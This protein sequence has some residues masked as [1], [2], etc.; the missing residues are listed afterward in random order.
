MKNTNTKTCEIEN[1]DNKILARTWC[2]KHYVRWYTKGDP[3]AKSQVAK[4]DSPEHSFLSRIKQDGECLI[5]LGPKNPQGYGSITL[6]GKTQP[7]YRYAYEREHGPIP[8]GMTIDHICWNRACVKSDH[9]RL[10]TYSQNNSNASGP[11]FSKRSP[12]PRNVYP[13]GK[14]GK[15]WKVV[16]TKDNKQHYFGGYGSIEEAAVVAEQA[17]Q[18]LFGEFAGKG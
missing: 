16:V 17:R 8:K 14:N 15:R 11:E 4:Y 10:A 18:E 5:W 3:L 1:C 12:G 2:S 9:L 13:V 6:N 7:V